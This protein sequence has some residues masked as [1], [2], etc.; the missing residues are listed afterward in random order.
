[1]KN[2]IEPRG[3]CRILY[4]SDPSSIATNLLPDPVES[5]DLRRWVDMLADNDVDTFDQ[6]VYSQGWTAYWRSDRYEY[7]RRT[8]HRRFLPMLDRGEQ[9][10]EVLID[11]SHK[12]GM[13]FIAGFRMNDNHGH[14][15]KEQGVGIASYIASHTELN[16]KEFPEGDY[17]KL[18]EPLD[19]TFEQV[20]E[21][22]LGVMGEVASKFDIDGVEMCFRDHAYFP[23]NKGRER[24]H[25]MTDLV[26]KVRT[27]LDANGKKL[28]LG[29]R[30]FSTIEECLD[31]GLDV[32]TWIAEGLLDYV[33]PQDTMYADFSVPYEE[34]SQ[35]TKQSDCRLYPGML[36]WT[37]VRARNRLNQI[38]LSSA[39]C[40]ALAKTMYGAGADGLSIYNH[41][42]SMWSVPFYPYSLAVFRELR[43]L[44]KI[45]SGERHYVFDPTWGGHMGFRVDRTSTGAIK[46]NRVV[47]DRVAAD[48]SGE[49]RFTLYE[50]LDAAHSAVLVFRGFGLTEEDRLDVRLNGHPIPASAVWQT[51]E[52]DAPPTEWQH[53][54]KAGG[55]EV[56]C[57]PEQARIDFRPEKE[58]ASSARWFCLKPSMVEYGGNRVQFT[59]V[60]GDPRATGAITIDEV[61]VFVQPQ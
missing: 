45:S 47:L 2:T 58:P 22:V 25:L 49:Y 56:K 23:L 5:D 31:M 50:D 43:D 10:L 4:V 32:G 59:L 41:F 44:G 16:L 51:R 53:V 21:Y 61:E 1:M 17:Y 42:C 52:S 39:N 38:P 48:P 19:F 26:R 3:T 60:Q 37:S 18:S 46:A 15:A 36:P 20:R 13:T 33:S 27:T 54:R 28:I 12:R 9:P 6:E 40:R 30:L 29:A 24:A 7:D 35:L 34:F 57:I 11:Q 14:Q 55:R 8:Q